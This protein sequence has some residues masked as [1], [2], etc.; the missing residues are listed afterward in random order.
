[1]ADA[2][3]PAILAETRFT[4]REGLAYRAMRTGAIWMNKLFFGAL[5]LLAIWLL[6]GYTVGTQSCVGGLPA[7]P[8]NGTVADHGTTQ[9]C[10]I[11]LTETSV[12]LGSMALLTF[13][14]S[15]AFGILGLVVGKQVLRMAPADSEPGA[16]NGG[17]GAGDLPPPPSP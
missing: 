12:Y 17:A 15:L 16:G 5:I 9:K 14:L 2:A 1:M 6:Y 13:A 4:V 3:K 11:L 10:S 8:T 7:A